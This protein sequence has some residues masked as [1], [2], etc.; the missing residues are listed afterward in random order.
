MNNDLVF[1]CHNVSIAL[2]YSTAFIFEGTKISFNTDLEKKKKESLFFF[3]FHS[4]SHLFFYVHSSLVH[5]E[6]LY[7]NWRYNEIMTSQEKRG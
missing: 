5:P 3:F 4:F 6:R 1:S 2:I 7:G